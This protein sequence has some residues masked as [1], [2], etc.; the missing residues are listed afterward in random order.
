MNQES[1][2]SHEQ[3]RILVALFFWRALDLEGGAGLVASLVRALAEREL[4]V[5]LVLPTRPSWLADEFQVVAYVRRTTIGTWWSYLCALRRESRVAA[6]TILL[7][8][9]PLWHLLMGPFVSA[10]ERITTHISSPAV[11]RE[12][13]ASGLR[14]QFLGHLVGKSH[15][16]ARLVAG[17]L[18]FR[19]PRYVVST[20]YQ[21][22]QLQALGCSPN[23]VTVM[24]FGVDPL[25]FAPSAARHRGAGRLVVGYL[26]H[27]SPI[28]GVS[29]LIDAFER[30]A[31][32][33]PGMLL[34]LA[35]SG[36]GTEGPLVRRMIETSPVRDR[37]EIV[38]RVEVPR[39]LED[40]DVTV[41]PFRSASLPHLPLVLLES[42][43]MGVPV[44]T[45]RVGGLGDVITNGENGFVVERGDAA[46]LAEVLTR[47]CDDA[48]LRLAM[49]DRI[50]STSPDRF[51][52]RAFCAALLDGLP[53]DAVA[54]ARRGPATRP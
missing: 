20:P 54:A 38:G 47:L 42:L 50:L 3:P 30:A 52:T 44:V 39:F 12:I 9:N 29:T 22:R 48:D 2:S 6:A 37:I 49:R 24:P 18:G 23:R 40:L 25:V 1:G 46:A 34:R 31:Q 19:S 8:N 41:L 16:A 10:P 43:A 11:G 36:K 7:D 35:W 14:R 13:L 53:A 32:A 26:G 5:R 15:F 33:R 4:R 21:A 45:T 17:A 28:K 27:F 51:S